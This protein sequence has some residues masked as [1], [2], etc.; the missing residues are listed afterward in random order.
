MRVG[1]AL[2]DG[3]AG[4]AVQPFA[5]AL[6]PIAHATTPRIKKTT[7]RSCRFVEPDYADQH[8]ADGFRSGLNGVSR[9]ERDGLVRGLQKRA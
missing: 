6:K 2:P 5:V 9:P 3:G 8:R 1:S 7:Q 4:C